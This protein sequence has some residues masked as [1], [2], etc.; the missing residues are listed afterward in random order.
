MLGGPMTE[1]SPGREVDATR[2]RRRWPL[3][4]LALPF[5]GTLWVPFYAAAEP[6]LW[7]IPYFYWY[8]FLWIGIGAALTGAVY[9]ATREPGA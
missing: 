7:G 1:G 3:L 9:F 8:Q 4:L 6:R 5:A 2:R